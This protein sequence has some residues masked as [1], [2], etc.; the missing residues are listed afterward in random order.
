MRR[1]DAA[2]S[3]ALVLA[4]SLVVH[5]YDNA[6]VAPAEQAAALAVAQAILKD[7]GIAVTWRDGRR[8]AGRQSARAGRSGSLPDSSSASSRRR[9]SARVR[10][11]SR[12]S[13]SRA[14]SGTLATVFADRIA[15]L[16][17]WRAPTPAGCS[18]APWRTRSAT[19]SSARHVTPTRAS[20]A[21][22]GRRVELQRDQPLGLDR[23][24][25]RRRP[26]APRP[27]RPARAA[28]NNPPRSSPQN[29][30]R[31]S[32]GPSVQEVPRSNGS[33][34]PERSE[35]RGP[36]GRGP[37][38]L[39]TL[40][41]PWTFGPCFCAYTDR[42]R[43]VCLYH[44]VPCP[45]PACRLRSWHSSSRRYLAVVSA[46]TRPAIGGGKAERFPSSKPALPT[47]R[48]P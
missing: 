39:W 15:R 38:T 17:S 12:L 30:R 3:H 20:C 6:G 26:D 22:S 45:F 43:G 31:R 34:G 36:R 42:P 16:A 25:P 2:C 7:V 24:P 44:E 41:T 29:P 47:C 32:R 35:T 8:R 28:P 23:C 21:A 13:T 37:W 27:G 46:Q 33:H 4:L 10:S 18:A 14:G 48:R 9:R 19:C 1:E 11:A 40:W 5:V